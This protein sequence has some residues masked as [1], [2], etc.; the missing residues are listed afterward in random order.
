MKKECLILKVDFEKVYDSVDWFFFGIY[1]EKV[2]FL[3]KME[4][5]DEGLCF[6][7]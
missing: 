5:L 3:R 2:W 1:V 7:W 6:W 4:G